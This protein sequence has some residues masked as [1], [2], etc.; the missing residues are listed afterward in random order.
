MDAEAAEVVIDD[1]IEF[2]IDNDEEPQKAIAATEDDI[3]SDDDLDFLSAD[4]VGVE[5]VDDIEEINML[6]A[7]DETATKLEL[8]YAYQN[9]GDMEGATEILQEVIK[10]GSD[11]QI[12]EASKLLGSL[13]GKSG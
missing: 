7:D 3:A 13:D 8:A 5:S 4:D 11:E 12:E 2:D 10:E 9:M 1:E 6:S